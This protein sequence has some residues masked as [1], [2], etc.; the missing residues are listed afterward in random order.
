M[1]KSAYMSRIVDTMK[2][3]MKVFLQ[4]DVFYTVDPHELLNSWEMIP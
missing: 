3:D 1:M 4:A 2:A